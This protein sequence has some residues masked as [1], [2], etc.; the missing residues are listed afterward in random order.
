MAEMM[1]Q[2]V[3]K[4]Y[5]VELQLTVDVAWEQDSEADALDAVRRYAERE[6]AEAIHRRA[7]SIDFVDIE[8][9]DGEEK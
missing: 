4:S 1:A 6:I 2:L 7:K 9:T 3:E 8:A 5:R